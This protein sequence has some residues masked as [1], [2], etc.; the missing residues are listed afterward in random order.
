MVRR[1][2]APGERH[3]CEAGS[4]RI[5]RYQAR[6]QDAGKRVESVLLDPLQIS[7]GLLSRLKRREDGICVNG[8]RAYAT[9]ILQA[10]DLVTAQVGDEAPPRRLEPV[11]MELTVLYEDEDFLL[12][13]KPANIPVHPTRDPQER[14]LE[15]GLLA[16][17]P[18][19]VYPHF[20][21]RLDKGTTGLMLTAKNGYAHELM[22]RR[23]HTD[24]FYREYL[25]V[26]EGIVA[27]P[28]GTVD[29]PIG[30]EDGSAYRHCVRTDGASSLTVYE[31]LAT[32]NGRTLLRLAPHTGRTHQL[33]VHMAYLG[34]PL[35]GDWLYGQRCV[36]ID[37][38]ALH[39]H[40]LIFI[41]PLSGERIERESPLPPDMRA[42]LI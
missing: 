26:A 9:R 27:P 40:R 5:I 28:A 6:E 10:G 39:S 3:S 24:A 34:F 4:P 35:T 17:L 15:Q 7:R 21:S 37:R 12:L 13:D 38:P 1:E 30:L 29:A 33:R 41:H 14:N 20:V 19:G 42:L 18:E 23:L 36:V 31:T 32:G 16:Y 11:Q 8:Q 25:A 22:K 2:I